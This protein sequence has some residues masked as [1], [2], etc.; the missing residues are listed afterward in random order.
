LWAACTSQAF[1]IMLQYHS[2][3]GGLERS[4]Q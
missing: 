4:T 2:L 1:Q 3:G